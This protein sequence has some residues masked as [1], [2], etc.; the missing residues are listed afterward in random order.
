MELGKIMN[1]RQ[2]ELGDGFVSGS[3]DFWTD[4]HCRQ[5]FGAF[6]TDMLAEKYDIMIGNRTNQLFMSRDT[7]E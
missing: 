3:I 6:I 1:D 2:S 7:K 4:P 5:C